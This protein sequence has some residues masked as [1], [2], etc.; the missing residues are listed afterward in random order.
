MRKVAM[1]MWQAVDAG[2]TESTL[3]G[4]EKPLKK[5]RK[6]VMTRAAALR[7]IMRVEEAA[8]QSMRKRNVGEIQKMGS[9]FGAAILLVRLALRGTQP[10]GSGAAQHP[11]LATNMA[12]A[13][14]YCLQHVSV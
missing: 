4:G 8:L 11:P 3:S 2:I 5:L 6:A 14:T 13:N 10:T 7:E 9:P 1:K 12:P